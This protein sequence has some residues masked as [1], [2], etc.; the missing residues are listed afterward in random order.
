MNEFGPQQNRE[1]VEKIKS[2]GTHTIEKE[3]IKITYEESYEELEPFQQEEMGIKGIRK[4]VITEAPDDFWKVFYKYDEFYNLLTEGEFPSFSTWNH[5]LWGDGGID[6]QHYNGRVAWK[7]FVDDGGYFQKVGGD[8]RR[9]PM[10]DKYNDAGEV[11]N[12]AMLVSG[13]G[14]WRESEDCPVFVFG[15]KNSALKDYLKQINENLEI[16]EDLKHAGWSF[17]YELSLGEKVLPSCPQTLDPES[18]DFFYEKWIVKNTS[19]VYEPKA[20]GEIGIDYKIIQEK[21]DELSKQ[22]GNERELAI[23]YWGLLNDKTKAIQYLENGDLFNARLLIPMYLADGRKEDAKNYLVK[24]LD[25]GGRGI[26]LGKQESLNT[27]RNIL[28]KDGIE[29]ALEFYFEE[30]KRVGNSVYINKNVPTFE[31]SYK[32]VWPYNFDNLRFLADGIPCMHNL[33]EMTIP[34]VNH[35]D[36]KPLR[37]CYADMEMVKNDSGQLEI[38]FFETD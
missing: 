11:F 29:K 26:N 10:K 6:R 32:I 4:K 23:I 13:D 7:K 9:G 16:R 28:E 15:S 17:D 18:E 20:Q 25:S 36:I 14:C 19:F 2:L 27:I 31:Q 1:S 22:K 35:K 21:I 33:R 3:G 30:C 12:L 24:I 37:W 5:A 34:A 8:V 38:I